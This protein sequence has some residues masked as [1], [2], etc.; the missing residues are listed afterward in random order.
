MDRAVMDRAVAAYQKI[1]PRLKCEDCAV[2]DRDN[3][4]IGEKNNY[5]AYVRDVTCPFYANYPNGYAG[6]YVE[7][8]G[9]MVR[10]REMKHCPREL[11][12]CADCPKADNGHECKEFKKRKGET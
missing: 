5:K 6:G 2:K 1:C 3:F 12:W 9:K 7:R 11:V 10:V 8:N 4:M